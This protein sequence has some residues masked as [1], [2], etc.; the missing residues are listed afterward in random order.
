MSFSIVD[1][2]FIFLPLVHE[3][4]LF[5]TSLSSAVICWLFDNNN[6]GRCEVIS[7]CGFD[8]LALYD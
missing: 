5:S 3:G 4:F 8:L 1:A 7:H 2:H 6:S